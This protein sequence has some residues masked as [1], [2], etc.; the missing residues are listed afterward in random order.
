M[1]ILC[2]IK[3]RLVFTFMLICLFLSVSQYAF[4]QNHTYSNPHFDKLKARTEAVVNSHIWQ[5]DLRKK[6]CTVFRNWG[7]VWFEM[8]KLHYNDLYHEIES[9]E[10]AADIKS[11][12]D[13]YYELRVAR[14]QQ[15][16]SVLTPKACR[17][18]AAQWLAYDNKWYADK[19][20]AEKQR[21]QE[22]R[23]EW[24]SQITDTGPGVWDG[25]MGG[26][27]LHIPREYIWFGSTA[28][29]GV[30]AQHNLLFHAPDMTAVIDPDF[31]YPGHDDFHGVLNEAPIIKYLPCQGFKDRT[32]CRALG[33]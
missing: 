7:Y 18:A 24:A 14:S 26:I 6:S 19:R 4:A 29:D 10:Q 31:P 9:E 15:D 33:A 21:I 20:A 28:K 17:E 22:Q 2:G 23:E 11:L 3:T 5:R 27:F 32:F 16:F 30:Q 1:K 8:G 25:V 12:Y 13:A